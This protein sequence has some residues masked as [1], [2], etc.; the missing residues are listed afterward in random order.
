MS[1]ELSKFEIAIKEHQRKTASGKLT[2]V[3]NYL[4][5]GTP[6]QKKTAEPRMREG[7]TDED[8]EKPDLIE[9]AM[10]DLRKYAEKHILPQSYQ[11]ELDDLIRNYQENLDLVMTYAESFES[12]ED[13]REDETYQDLVEIQANYLNQI[14]K[15]VSFGKFNYNE[16]L[17]ETKQAALDEMIE[18]AGMIEDEQFKLDKD[19]DELAKKTLDF[20]DLDY[21]RSGELEKDIFEEK[22]HSFTSAYNRMYEIIEGIK[23]R[24]ADIPFDEFNELADD[25]L[26]MEKTAR[27]RLESI[28]DRV[29]Y[30]FNNYMDENDVWEENLKTTKK[31]KNIWGYEFGV[32]S[33]DKKRI[34]SNIKRNITLS[35]KPINDLTFKIESIMKDP[36][37]DIYND[38][39]NKKRIP[40][41]LDRGNDLSKWLNEIGQEL[42]DAIVDNDVVEN[43]EEIAIKFHNFRDA[44]SKE[45]KSNYSVFNPLLSFVKQ[46]EAKSDK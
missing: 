10:E 3:T 7:E 36:I 35:L 18:F 41:H 28:G 25:F 33:K 24:G 21:Y 15:M 16:N 9:L 40:I 44:I 2:Y 29:K 31:Y 22:D 38:D 39:W 45:W 26:K 20:E 4:R 5:K 43:V 17:D 27:K 19:V 42:A 13:A 14:R 6:A 11:E 32:N 12:I 8:E 23:Y 1:E 46:S 34:I 37:W 30:Y